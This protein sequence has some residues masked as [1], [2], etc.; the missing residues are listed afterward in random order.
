MCGRFAST[1]PPDQLANYF[2]AALAEQLAPG[3]EGEEAPSA[4][5]NVAP[6]QG[7]YTVYEDGGVRRLDTFHW[8]LVPFWAK[9]PKLGNRMIN[10]R[11]E[12]VAVVPC[13]VF[14]RFSR[15]DLR[16]KSRRVNGWPTAL[17]AR[18]LAP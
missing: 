8:G 18:R 10:A 17:A 14:A 4:N 6:T 5:Y 7:V 12:T 15:L 1:T 16:S 9:D 2:G 3:A 13:E 11:A